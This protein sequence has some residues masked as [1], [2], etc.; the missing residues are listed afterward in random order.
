[1]LLRLSQCVQ[2]S[3]GVAADES[4]RR[5]GLVEVVEWNMDDKTFPKTSRF[6][7]LVL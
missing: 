1:M 7:K 6:A 5:I 3:T 4:F 2:S